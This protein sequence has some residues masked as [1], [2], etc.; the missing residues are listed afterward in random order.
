[1]LES[2]RASGSLLKATHEKEREVIQMTMQEFFSAW[3][4]FFQ[5][6]LDNYDTIQAGIDFFVNEHATSY[7][8][9]NAMHELL[10]DSFSDL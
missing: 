9:W 4:D 8:E 5:N 7:E 10:E 2:F 3:N 1:V 6:E